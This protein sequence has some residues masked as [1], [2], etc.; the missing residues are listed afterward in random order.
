MLIKTDNSKDYICP[1]L[2]ISESNFN[3]CLGEKCAWYIEKPSGF[4]YCGIIRFHDSDLG[5]S[6]A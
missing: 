5:G 4:G 6:D 1:V 2:S 3:Y